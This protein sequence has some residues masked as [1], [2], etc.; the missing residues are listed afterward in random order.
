MSMDNLRELCSRMKEQQGRKEQLEAELTEVNKALD[1][2][3]MRQIPPLMESL[4]VK[5][6]TFEGLGRVQ[7]ASD[8]FASTR[9]G[10]KDAAMQWLRDCGYEDMITETYNAS[11][12]KA[13]FRRLLKDH[14]ATLKAADPFEWVADPIPAEIFAVTPFVRASIVGK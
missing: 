7:L 2:L 1:D 12:I 6:A 14:D 10:K 5:T 11:S 9:E 4:Q 8:I 3:R 13:L